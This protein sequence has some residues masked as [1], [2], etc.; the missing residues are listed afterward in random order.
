MEYQYSLTKIY[1]LPVLFGIKW[2]FSS[3]EDTSLRNTILLKCVLIKSIPTSLYSIIPIMSKINPKIC[4]PSNGC[5]RKARVT[6]QIMSVRKLSSTIRVVAL[7]SLV[8]LMP[9]KLKKAIL[10]MLPA[11]N[12]NTLNKI[13]NFVIHKRGCHGHDHMIVGKYCTAKG[14]SW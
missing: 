3:S 2:S 11:K 8:T 9:A 10:N 7:I 6:I 5:Q 14:L 13:M 4:S 1:L 12:T